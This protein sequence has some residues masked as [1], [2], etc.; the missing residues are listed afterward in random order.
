MKNKKTSTTAL[1]RIILEM[2]KGD[3]EGLLEDLE[4]TC[5]RDES[6]KDWA[7]GCLEAL[8]DE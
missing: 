6:L 3:P 1:L 5:D 7:Q 8:E 4:I 2:Y